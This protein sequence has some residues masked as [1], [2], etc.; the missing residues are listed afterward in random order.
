MLRHSTTSAT[1][2]VAV[3]LVVGGCSG[4]AD[5]APTTTTSSGTTAATTTSITSVTT[6]TTQ[7]PTSTTAPALPDFLAGLELV[8]MVTTTPS[9]GVGEVP[10]FGWEAV[11]G[12]ESYVLHVFSGDGRPLWTWTGAG[13]SVA[14]GDTLAS[15]ADGPSLTTPG[16]WQV[17]AFEGAALIGASPMMGI[18]P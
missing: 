10:T 2:L 9:Q 6:A 12:A 3:L 13:T 4:S 15:V 14:L 1:R 5:S 18:A 8:Q 16:T 11:P 17:F 7:A